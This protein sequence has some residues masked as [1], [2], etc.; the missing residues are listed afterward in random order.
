MSTWA[1][2]T[3]EQRE[4]RRAQRRICS[5]TEEKRARVNSRNA[6][7]A[8]AH[9]DRVK[10]SVRKYLEANRE[11][12]RV[13]ALASYHADPE[14]HRKY[15][16]KWRTDNLEKARETCRVYSAKNPRGHLRGY[17]L[18]PKTFDEIAALQ[19]G[20]CALC[21]TQLTTDKRTHVDHDHKTGRIRG[22]LC[23][24]CN[25]GLGCFRDSIEAMEQA[26]SYVRRGVGVSLETRP[27]FVK[28]KSRNKARRS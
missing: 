10:A 2:M 21:D 6:V 17:G 19:G 22:F 27:M 24:N 3:P 15:R 16:R 8:K 25:M 26:V 5:M 11:K 28:W 4:R 14:R 13:A 23:R 12:I 1:T 9:P 20:K 18:S 7:W